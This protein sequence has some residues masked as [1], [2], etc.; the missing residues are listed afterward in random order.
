MFVG[1]TKKIAE[2]FSGFNALCSEVTIH[3]IVF[4]TTDDGFKEDPHQENNGNKI[5]DF[6]RLHTP[7]HTSCPPHHNGEARSPVR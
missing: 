1:Y 4:R 3:A 7:I 6:H 5:E 2:F